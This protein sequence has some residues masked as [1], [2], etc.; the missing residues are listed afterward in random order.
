M[1]DDFFFPIKANPDP[2]VLS[3]AVEGGAGL[4]LCSRGDLALA[5]RFLVPEG[6]LNFTS[7]HLDRDLAADLLSAGVSIDL[8][9]PQQLDVLPMGTPAVG[10]RVCTAEPHSPYGSK[11]GVASDQIAALHAS[12]R[13]R[14]IRLSG[15]HVHTAHFDVLSL[16]D[17]LLGVLRQV[18]LATLQSVER[19][20]LGGGWPT[21]D[22][23]SPSPADLALATATI[24][25]SLLAM[26]YRG[27][28]AIEPGEW[29]VG[30]C[31]WFVARVSGVKPHPF[32]AER[33]VVILDAA[34]PVPC[35]PSQ[36]PFEI[37]RD[38]A[39]LDA[40]QAGATC[41]IYGSANT[42]LDTL[43]VR[44]TMAHPRPGDMLAIG[45]QGAYAR[46]LTGTFNERKT[47]PI[48]VVD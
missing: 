2:H 12:L 34:T 46:Q 48:V 40:D 3:I 14:G 24:R 20:N 17:R 37:L 18:P 1:A 26:G 15:L 30:P 38:G 8:D 6:R 23:Q 19:I 36:G 33:L 29:I 9:S 7:P 22:L 39:W 31:A 42:G 43:G 44:V 4:D 41:D 47:P 28:L 11:F 21:A 45:C 25:T 27:R 10:I 13:A 35:R 5:G 32:E 16:S